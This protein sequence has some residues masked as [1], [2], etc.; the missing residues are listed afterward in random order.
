MASNTNGVSDDASFPFKL[1]EFFF[2]IAQALS[3]FLFLFPL[4]L[5]LSP[6]ELF[7]LSLF[8]SSF[9]F[10]VCFAAAVKNDSYKKGIKEEE[11]E[12]E[13]GKVRRRK[14]RN[15]RLHAHTMDSTDTR[16]QWRMVQRCKTKTQVM[17]M[18][19][20]IVCVFLEQFSLLP[21]KQSLRRRVHGMK[22][23]KNLRERRTV[24]VL[25]SLF[26]SYH[27]CVNFRWSH[28]GIQGMAWTL[29]S[30]ALLHGLLNCIS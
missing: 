24:C 21:L 6:F 10:A 16:D 1:L 4:F 19:P 15:A 25:D 29:S 2:T 14:A 9:L 11:G 23:R 30:L 26:P 17:Q 13:E 3:F 27:P 20:L 18:I 8:S 7:S 5:S 22:K 28:K 12:E